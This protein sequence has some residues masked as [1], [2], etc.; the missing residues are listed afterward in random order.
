[1]KACSDCKYYQRKPDL[2][3]SISGE[4]RFNPPTTQ[5]QRFPDV[6][7]DDWCGKF[8]DKIKGGFW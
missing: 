3:G 2:K 8:K 4:C 5:H 6:K 7:K 1:M